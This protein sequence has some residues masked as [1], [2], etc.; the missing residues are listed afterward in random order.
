MTKNADI[1]KYKYSGYGIGFDK[2]GSFSFPGG[3][4]GK[5]VTILGVDMS[6]STNIDNAKK[7]IL[8][9]GKGPTQGLEHR[10]SAEKIYSINFTEH[11]RKFCLRLYYSGTNNYLFVNV[12][13]IIKFKAKDSEIVAT[14]LC[15]GNISRD[16]SVDNVRNT[17]LNGFVYDFN[18]DYDA[19]TVDDILYS[20]NYLM[21]N[22]DIV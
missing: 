10:L 18:V 1:D 3:R 2:K 11:S 22:N 5:N 14:P 7:D 16:W 6:S 20:H 12:T 8:I 9:F 15:L 17:G 4:L 19:I 13:E 21:E